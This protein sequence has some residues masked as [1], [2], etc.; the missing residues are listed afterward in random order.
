MLHPG[1]LDGDLVRGPPVSGA[2]QPAP[3]PVGEPPAELEDPAAQHLVWLV[4][5]T[6]PRAAGLS[7]TV[8][9]PSGKRG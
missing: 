7:S 9:G 3:N 4:V 6:M 5:T 1:D 8:R 2:G